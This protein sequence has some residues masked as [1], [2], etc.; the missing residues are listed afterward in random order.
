MVSCSKDEAFIDLVGLDEDKDGTDQ[1]GNGSENPDQGGEDPDPGNGDD[2][3]QDGNNGTDFDSSEGLKISTTPCDFTL[4]G[5][6]ANATVE[7]DCRMD[8]GGQTI[9]LPAGVALTFKGGE[10]INGTL[11]FSGQGVIDGNLLNK[12]LNV[13]GDVKLNNTEFQFYPER[14]DIQQ[15]TVGYQRALDN[16]YELEGVINLVKELSGTTFYIDKF[17]AFFEITKVTSTSN[18]NFYPSVEAINVPSDFNL[19]MT[20]NTHLR[21]FPNGE[22][23]YA[24]LAVREVSNVTISGG[25]LHGDRDSH[26]YSMGGSME[27][28]HL[29]DLHAAENTRISGVHMSM[30]LGDGMK[31][32]SLRHTFESNYAPSN[33][34][35]VTDCVFDNNR[36]NNL[37]ITDGYNIIIENNTFLNASNDTPN[38][39][40]VDPGFA[41]DVEAFRSRGSDGE[42]IYYEIAKDITIR[43][44]VER[45]SRVGG[46]IV[47]IGYNV[48]IEDNHSERGISFSIAN[49]TRIVGNTIEAVS[50][51]DREKGFGIKAGKSSSESASIYDNK[52]LGNR[53]IGCNI[54]IYVGNVDVEVSDNTIEDFNTGIYPVNV[55]KSVI[56]DNTMS[57]N[58]SQSKGVFVF[59]TEISDVIFEGNDIQVAGDPFRFTAVNEGISGYQ[60]VNVRGNTLRSSNGAVNFTR[61][62]GIR[63]ENNEMQNQGMEV[64]SSNGLDIVGNTINN[65]GNG[66]P[67]IRLREVNRDIA[68]NNNNIIVDNG[69]NCIQVDSTTSTSEVS[70]SNNNCGN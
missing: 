47:S 4:N 25:N 37:S 53:I 62:N 69:E 29:L 68:I 24:L 70:Q 38:S 36:R 16:R 52:V 21:V 66:D 20:D 30:A 48:T 18:L 26:D 22:K 57:S 14:W 59:S 65:T 49:G 60:N 19:V 7:I 13:E 5:V 51:E 58:R 9:T 46:F 10:I 44:N 8:L 1:D 34:I 54:G 64:F 39:T 3:S 56:R 63:F 35:V 28:G 6:E 11:N 45:N 2:G 50:S 17:D 40:G 61:A 23:D 15:G 27:W 31:I 33:N 32:H 67:G 41:I 55:S 42:L 12:S 43:N